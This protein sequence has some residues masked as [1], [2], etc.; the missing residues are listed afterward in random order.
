MQ[1]NFNLDYNAF[2]Q[3]RLTSILVQLIFNLFLILQTRKRERVEP[4]LKW[5]W[6]NRNEHKWNL[7]I[8]DGKF[9]AGWKPAVNEA[10]A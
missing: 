8:G 5:N 6:W 3:Y 7:D 4:R 2:Y 1:F 9:D 10:H